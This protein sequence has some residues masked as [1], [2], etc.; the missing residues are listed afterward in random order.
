MARPSEVVVKTIT[1]FTTDHG[2]KRRGEGKRITYLIKKHTSKFLR[3]LKKPHRPVFTNASLIKR[4]EVRRHGEEEW[5]FEKELIMKFDKARWGKKEQTRNIKG[6]ESLTR[7]RRDPNRVDVR[8]SMPS[9]KGWFWHRFLAWYLHNDSQVTLEE[10]SKM[11]ADHT[12]RNPKQVDWRRLRIVE[13]Q[14][15]L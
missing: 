8:I 15:G 9:H 11:H 4:T 2:K 7:R 12:N 5:K 1:K 3:C 10:F 14:G 13:D 6:R